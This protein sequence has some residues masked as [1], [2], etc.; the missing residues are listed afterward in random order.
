MIEISPVTL[1]HSVTSRAIRNLLLPSARP[2]RDANLMRDQTRFKR[3]R[4]RLAS[5]RVATALDSVRRNGHQQ[6][7][8]FEKRLA[9]RNSSDSVEVGQ[10]QD[11]ILGIVAVMAVLIFFFRDHSGL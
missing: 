6:F 9:L 4:H 10:H 1:T 3:E 8:R 7:G 2:H 11:D 5:D